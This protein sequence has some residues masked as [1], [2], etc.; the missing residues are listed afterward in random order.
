[1][2]LAKGFT[3]DECQHFKVKSLLDTLCWNK[4][5]DAAVGKYKASANIAE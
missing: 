4:M 3:T 5:Y 1:M 2:Y